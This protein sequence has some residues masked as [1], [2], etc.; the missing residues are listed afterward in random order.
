MEWNALYYGLIY[1]CD[2]CPERLDFK[3]KVTNIDQ[4]LKGKV[5]NNLWP[6]F[7]LI[8]Q[9]D[10]W[11]NT[12]SDVYNNCIEGNSYFKARS[13]FRYVRPI[14]PRPTLLSKIHTVTKHYR[15]VH[16]YTRFGAILCIITTW[17][18]ITCRI[19]VTN[20]DVEN[21]YS[22][23]NV[24]FQYRRHYGSGRYYKCFPLI[25]WAHHVMPIVW[26][27]SLSSPRASERRSV[28][29]IVTYKLYVGLN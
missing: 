28:D 6:P 19:A 10:Y 11:L 16:R 3:P 27:C 24:H 22:P 23:G 15:A 12:I 20:E 25:G 1:L 7:L 5:M 21:A 4:L 29:T 18:G 8:L 9:P 17:R 13:L 26:W 2:S 14:I